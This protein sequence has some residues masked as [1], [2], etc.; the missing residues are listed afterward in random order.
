MSLSMKQ[1]HNNFTKKWLDDND[2]LI[3]SNHDDNKLMV[4]ERFIRT[5]KR[6]AIKSRISKINVR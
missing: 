2:V 1:F 3:Y 4:A 5:L 6:K